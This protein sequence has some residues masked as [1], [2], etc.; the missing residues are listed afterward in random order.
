MWLKMNA[1]AFFSEN[2]EMERDSIF[3]I[4]IRI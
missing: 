2:W 1:G 3:A 4:T